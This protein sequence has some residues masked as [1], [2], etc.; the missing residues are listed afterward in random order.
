MSVDF[1]HRARWLTGMVTPAQ[2]VGGLIAAL[3]WLIDV[4]FP[5]GTRWS[6][7]IAV[8]V[9]GAGAS[10]LINFSLRR[11]MTTL[12][13]LGDGTLK[14]TTENLGL[15]AVEVAQQPESTFWSALLVMVV[16]GT[17][18][19]LA[20][21]GFPGVPWGSALRVAFISL[22]SSPLVGA[23]AMLLT[24]PRSRE[25]LRQLVEAGLQLKTLH[26]LLPQRF[27]FSRRLVGYTL[28]ALTT[29]LLLAFELGFARYQQ[30]LEALLEGEANAT[31]EGALASLGLILV[32]LAVV[33]F[34]S[35]RAGELAGQPL[36][37]LAAATERLANGD[38]RAPRLIPSEYETW[39][40]VTSLGEME[41]QLGEL[42]GSLSAAAGS[43]TAAT[44]S[45]SGHEAPAAES[46][47]MQRAHLDTTS[48]TT[49][50]LARSAREIARNAQRVSELAAA[51]LTAARSGRDS[52]DGFLRA[53]AQV[54]EGN[55]AIADS[56]VR[57]NKRVQQVGRII[58]FIDGIAD[59]SDLL[60]LNAELEGNKAGEVGRGFSLVAA[61]MRRLAESVMTSTREIGGL[62]DEIRDA[63]N[64]A[65]MATEAGVKATDAGA[66]LAQRVGGGFARI[67]DDAN[68]SSTAS[69]SISLATSQQQVGTDQLAI[70]MRDILR[71]TE[72]ST[73]ATREMRDAHDR[74]ISLAEGLQR[75]GEVKS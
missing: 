25:L 71:N 21:A 51:T 39:A 73:L 46:L 2:V 55:Q 52:A 48:A 65:V 17:L 14:P 53:M 58:E 45:L 5:E 7:A 49:E 68:Q 8:V 64:A 54:R 40:A 37:E 69:Q 62:I 35:M 12:R 6:F 60:A 38:Y 29:P 30:L 13:A 32:V 36:T 16:G 34:T 67:V 63:T 72:T 18:T 19:G 3:Y 15:A 70:A 44:A 24:V 10:E 4:E 74:L 20:W 9:A 28:C 50:E 43:I 56:V 57:L 23:L 26:T 66:A 47:G 61:E 59:K 75:V 22:I 33:G 42:L 41:L 27:V 11:R 31:P 1:K